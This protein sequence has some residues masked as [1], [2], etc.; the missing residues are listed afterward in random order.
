MTPADHMTLDLTDHS[1]VLVCRHCEWRVVLDADRGYAWLVAARHM[2]HAHGL[3][4]AG[5]MA[6][7]LAARVT[8]RAAM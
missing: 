4:H 8:A 7:E 1:A 3:A 5:R 6:R 2:K